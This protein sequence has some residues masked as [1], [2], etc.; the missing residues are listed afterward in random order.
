MPMSPDEAL[1][2]AL[3][4]VRQ[5]IDAGWVNGKLGHLCLQLIERLEDLCLPGRVD[6]AVGPVRD[7][8]YL[9]RQPTKDRHDLLIVSRFPGVQTGDPLGP[10]RTEAA[11]AGSARNARAR[12]MVIRMVCAVLLASP[13][14]SANWAAQCWPAP[15]IRRRISSASMPSRRC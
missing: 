1:V 8:G 11:S 5:P 7:G 15:G 6:T 3:G 4:G 14:S 10:G 13:R 12:L 9:L 2:V